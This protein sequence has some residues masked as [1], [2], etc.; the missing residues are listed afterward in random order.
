MG[1]NAIENFSKVT[2]EF[3]TFTPDDDLW[4]DQDKL[5]KQVE[6]FRNNSN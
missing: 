4:T 2:G 5:K 3:F 6:F 1:G